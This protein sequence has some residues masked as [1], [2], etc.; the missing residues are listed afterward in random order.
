MGLDAKTERQT[1]LQGGLDLESIFKA[2]NDL[3]DMYLAELIIHFVSLFTSLITSKRGKG[4]GR[5]HCLHCDLT[6]DFVKLTPFYHF[7]YNHNSHRAPNC[8]L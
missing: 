5:A 1:Q 7:K 2:S 3:R 4:S 6:D 8:S